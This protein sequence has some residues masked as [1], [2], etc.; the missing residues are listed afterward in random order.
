MN[1]DPDQP[2]RHSLRLAGYD[3]AATGG[4]FVTLC[5]HRQAHLFG[6]VLADG[7][8][9]LNACGA[10][11]T[12]EWTRSAIVRHEI[13]LDAFVVMPNH[14]HGIVLVHA[15]DRPVAPTESRPQQRSLGAFV[16]GFKSVVT[17]RINEM[18]CTPGAPVWQ[19][20]YYER[21]IRNDREYNAI[22]EYI[23]NNPANW[24]NDR[25]NAA[26]S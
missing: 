2:R 9:L 22:R 10:I 19:R 7:A 5:T 8:M 21:I 3:Y 6:A 24:A 15:G 18:R 17:R 12:K 25:E 13:A 20:N 1:L 11:V 23:L 4:Y 14:I 16:A 26:S